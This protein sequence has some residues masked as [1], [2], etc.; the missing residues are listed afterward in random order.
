MMPLTKIAKSATRAPPARAIRSRKG[1]PTGAQNDFGSWTAP[2]TVTNLRV[3]GSP[4]A[5]LVDV[6]QGLD[7]VDHAADLQAECRPEE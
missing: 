4:E 1:V 7:V 2:A 5:A 3:T 6:V